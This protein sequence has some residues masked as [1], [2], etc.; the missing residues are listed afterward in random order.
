MDSLVFVQSARQREWN[1]LS[2]PLTLPEVLLQGLGMIFPCDDLKSRLGQVLTLH[3][4]PEASLGFKDLRVI[5]VCWAG[6]NASL[7]L[8]SIPVEKS[9]TNR[10]LLAL[11]TL[12]PALIL[13]KGCC[14]CALRFSRAGY[15]GWGVFLGSLS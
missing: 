10:H 8:S 1:P 2:Y 5:D 11:S 14:I 3:W 9:K 4:H 6:Q 12:L 15:K 7:C 13:V